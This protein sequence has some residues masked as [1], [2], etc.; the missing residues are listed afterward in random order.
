[1]KPITG[2]EESRQNVDMKPVD[3]LL[4]VCL[5]LLFVATW[6]C[7]LVM[8]HRQPPCRSTIDLHAHEL[9]LLR[10]HAKIDIM[11][12]TFLTVRVKITTRVPQSR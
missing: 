5:Q 12:D 10:N 2:T 3:A 11:Q 7:S 6:Q 8:C 9:N 4:V 1:M